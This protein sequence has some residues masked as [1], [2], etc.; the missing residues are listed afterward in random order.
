MQVGVS[1][2][3]FE[4]WS[5]ILRLRK[6]MA[7]MFVYGDFSMVDAEHDDVFAYSRSFNGKSVLV[8]CN[9]RERLVEWTLPLGLR[10]AKKEQVLISTHDDVLLEDDAVLLRP[11]EA[12]ACVQSRLSSR[13]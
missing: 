3:P 12:F 13:L 6:T 9:F 11:F 10:G 4:H 7:D 5:S 1:G 2:S 8:I